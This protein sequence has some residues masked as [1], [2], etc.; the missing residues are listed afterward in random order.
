MGWTTYHKPS[1]VT[2]KQSLIDNLVGT[3]S[4]TDKLLSIVG[5]CQVGSVHYFALNFPSNYPNFETGFSEF[6]RN[7]DGSVTSMLIALTSSNKR[8]YYNF[9]YK[10]IGEECG[11]YECKPTQKLFNMLTPLKSDIKRYA[12]DW[13]S[14]VQANFAKPKFK[15]FIVGE[16]IELPNAIRFIDGKERKRFIVTSYNNKIRFNCIDTSAVCRL[17]KAQQITAIRA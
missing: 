17:S 12:A 10:F 3:G 6:E 11:P 15:K 8:D 7:S 14:K 1:N 2:A 9:G 4:N 16:K 13:R 5:H